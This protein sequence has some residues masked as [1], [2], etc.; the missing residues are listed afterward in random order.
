MQKGFAPILLILIIVVVA[1]IGSGYYF[2]YI[3]GPYADGNRLVFPE[4]TINLTKPINLTSTPTS[5]P[6]S[7]TPVKRQVAV[8]EI[9]NG[10]QKTYVNSNYPDL[11]IVHDS[12]WILSAT[13]FEGQVVKEGVDAAI[14]LKKNNTSLSFEITTGTAAGATPGCFSKKEKPYVLISNGLLRYKDNIYGNYYIKDATVEEDKTKFNE[15]IR[16]FTNAYTCQKDNSCAMCYYSGDNESTVTKT[17]F[18]IPTDAP[19]YYS[20]VSFIYYAMVRI[21]VK[22]DD[23]DQILLK[24]ADKIVQDSLNSSK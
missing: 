7:N 6:V 22:Q 1:I 5:V 2:F 15:L 8:T 23:E 18:P 11:K 21:Y 3:A 12:S 19:G 14:L 10:S 13:E 9:D 17:I 20:R 16:V 24:E 4:K